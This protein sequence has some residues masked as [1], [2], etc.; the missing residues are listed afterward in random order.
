MAEETAQERIVR[1]LTDA[2]AAEVG[3]LGSLQDLEKE[4]THAELSSMVT[5]HIAVTQSQIARLQA[6]ITAL[7]GH[8]HGGKNIV[9]TVIAKGSALLNV[10]HDKEDKLTQDVIKAYAFEYFEVGA[11]TSL[12]AYASS[13]GDHETAQLADTLIN[14]EQQAGERLGRLISQVAVT[15]VNKTEGQ[16]AVS[17]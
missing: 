16:G 12:K 4:S 8:E 3:G 17:A 5:E 10:F 7:G 13:V 1:Y 11:Y 15:A 9:N 14:E 6:R 2:H